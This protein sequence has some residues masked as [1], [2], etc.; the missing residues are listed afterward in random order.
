MI[1]DEISVYWFTASATSSARLYRESLTSAMRGSSTASSRTNWYGPCSLV[2]IRQEWSRLVQH[3]V[4][5]RTS[6]AY[7]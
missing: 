3:V 5:L 4:K 7:R 6:G 1:L 2:E